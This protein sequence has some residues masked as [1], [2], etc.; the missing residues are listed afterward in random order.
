MSRFIFR[1]D[2]FL[3]K[4]ADKLRE[5]PR[6]IHDEMARRMEQK[7]REVLRAQFA[8]ARDPLGRP[9]LPPK[10]GHLPPMRRT[11]ALEDG[12]TVEAVSTSS[13]IFLNVTASVEYAKYLQTGTRRMKARQIVPATG[14]LA[15]TWRRAIREANQESI[16]VWYRG[17][18]L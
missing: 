11:G 15:E 14:V 4:L 12:L 9:Y 17:T 5:A 6:Q 1:D 18:A 7:L 3:K 8:E 2:P 13:G 10:D 16:E